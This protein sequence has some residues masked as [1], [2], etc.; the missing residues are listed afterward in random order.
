MINY[1][2]QHIAG[3]ISKLLRDHFGKGPESVTVAIGGKYIIVHLRSFLTSSERLLLAQ[4]HEMIIHQMRDK[5]MQIMIPDMARYIE[6]VTGIKPQHFYYDW[7]LQNKSGV[8]VAVCPEPVPDAP[9]VQTSYEG[10]EEIEQAVVSLGD[11]SEKVP[12]DIHSFEVYPRTIL[13]VRKGILIR[14]EKEFIRLGHGELLKAV[15]R[16]LERNYLR[17][18]NRLEEILNRKISDFFVDYHYESDRSMVVI[19][20]QDK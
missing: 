3:Y 12:E 2:Q 8:L 6:S 10:R 1:Y 9:D 17:H 5:L 19:M 11:R 13:I 18:P 15:K 20:M 7:A 4:E 14:I 16:N